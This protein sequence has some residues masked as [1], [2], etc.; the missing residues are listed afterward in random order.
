MLNPFESEQDSVG[1]LILF[2]ARVWAGS[3][4]SVKQRN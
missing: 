3:P 4:A 1:S 2:K